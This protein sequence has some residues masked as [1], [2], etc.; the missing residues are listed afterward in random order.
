MHRLSP[1]LGRAGAGPSSL[2]GLAPP[3]PAPATLPTPAYGWLGLSLTT[4]EM[5]V[6]MAPRAQPER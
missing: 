3:T 1:G 5:G 6:P 2:E 4:C